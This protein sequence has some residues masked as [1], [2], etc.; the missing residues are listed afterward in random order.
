MQQKGSLSMPGK[1]YSEN[2]WVQVMRSIGR[3]A[4]G[5]IA[6]CERS[7]IPTI[8]LLIFDFCFLLNFLLYFLPSLIFSLYFLPYSFTF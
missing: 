1:W 4:G 3:E 8:A 5:R 7:L 6:Q 2:F